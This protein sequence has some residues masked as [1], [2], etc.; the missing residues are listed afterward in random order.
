MIRARWFGLYTAAAL[1][2]V[3][4]TFAFL[5][6][7]LLGQEVRVGAWRTSLVSGSPD[8]DAYTR[9]KVA[10]VALL[11]LAREETLY[12]VAEHDSRGARLRSLC[13]YRITGATPA[14]R[15]WS[16]TAYA[17]D[18]FLFADDA[19]RYSVGSSQLQPDA[20]GRFTMST[21]PLAPG[22]GSAWIP[23]P[24]DR[25]LVLTLRL[26]NPDPAIAA[27]PRAFAAPAIEPQG[28]CR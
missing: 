25:G 17:D 21:G 4:L 10:R 1:A 8:A 15:W 23:T 5:R 7:P 20:Q 22:D 16:I 9:A 28:D 24:G 14:A 19:R 11:A 12:Y 26:Y 27:D 18:Y 13:R 6:S 2:G 3:G